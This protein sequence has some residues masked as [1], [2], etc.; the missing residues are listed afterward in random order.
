MGSFSI[1]VHHAQDA[2]ASGQ[3]RQLFRPDLWASF[4]RGCYPGKRTEPSFE[5]QPQEHE[6]AGK[7]KG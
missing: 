1:P 7:G 5:A 2:E 6:H 3:P 4:W